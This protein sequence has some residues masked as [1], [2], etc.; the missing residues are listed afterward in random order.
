MNGSVSNRGTIAPGNS[1]GTLTISGTYTH[2]S[3]ATYACEIAAAGTSDLIK[4]GS[5][6]LKGGTVNATL[7]RSF[8]RG[9]ESWTLWARA[10]GGWNARSASGGYMG[11]S[12]ASGG[13][14]VGADGPVLPWL[15]LGFAL[16]AGNTDLNWSQGGYDGDQRALSSGLYA[17]A[18]FG[19]LYLDASVSYTR[20]YNTATRAVSFT[21]MD[22]IA[23]SSFDS[24]TWLGRLGGGYDF[25]AGGWLLGPAAL[26]SYMKL[27][28][29]GFRESGADYLS[30]TVDDRDSDYWSTLLG[31]RAAARYDFGPT[32]LLP[33]MELGWRHCLTDDARTITASFRDYS[34]SPFSITGRE[35]APDMLELSARL[36]LTMSKYLNLFCQYGLT[37]GDG[38]TNQ[39]L[40]A[41]LNIVF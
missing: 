1:I 17:S 28:E 15:T 31:F 22:T 33:R 9:G 13:V 36:T 39:R 2:E 37:W 14:A 30:L 5:A 10:L 34:G 20:L 35:S 19:S 23:S 4:A 11:Y 3:T 24:Q 7:P 21:A 40:I 25:R 32:T 27:S 29:D 12:A 8:Y 18:D 26:L 6:N 16:G 38:L 41:G